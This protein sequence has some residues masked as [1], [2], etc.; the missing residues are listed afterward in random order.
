MVTKDLFT[1]T[2]TRYAPEV[3]QTT[4]AT[5]PSCVSPT[6]N[7]I[8]DPLAKIEITILKTIFQK[9]NSAKFKRGVMANTE[10]KKQFVEE[11]AAK[12]QAVDIKKRA[13]DASVVTVT[14]TNTEQFVTET[15]TQWTTITTTIPTTVLATV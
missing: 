3:T 14:A 7:W 10:V 6:P 11:R 2:K 4:V 1:V 15:K 9:V 5:T 12:L 8:P 13:P